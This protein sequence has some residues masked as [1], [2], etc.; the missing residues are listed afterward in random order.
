MKKQLISL[1]LNLDK[2]ISSAAAGWHRL[3][4]R[5]QAGSR[6]YGWRPK[7]AYDNIGAEKLPLDL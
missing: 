7:I 2:T 5:Q 6:C 4:S 1:G 3:E